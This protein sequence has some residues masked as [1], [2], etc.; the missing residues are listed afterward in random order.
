M[1]MHNNPY[2]P[3]PLNA[4]SDMA[5]PPATATKTAFT[6]DSVPMST[7]PTAPMLPPQPGRPNSTTVSPK[8]PLKGS[9][10]RKSGKSEG[11]THQLGPLFKSR[12]DSAPGLPIKAS[13]SPKYPMNLM[14]VPTSHVPQGADSVLLCGGMSLV[15][16]PDASA[17]EFR[18]V[19]E[20]ISST[21]KTKYDGNLKLV[22]YNIVGGTFV[23][24]EEEYCTATVRKALALPE[25]EDISIPAA[26][27]RTCAAEMWSQYLTSGSAAVEVSLV[28]NRICPLLDIPEIKKLVSFNG[29]I[30]FKRWLSFSCYCMNIDR[31]WDQEML[32]TWSEMKYVQL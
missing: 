14:R 12:R 8:S 1:S 32:T 7:T 26:L 11:I 31:S 18:L 28:V 21:N 30:Y 27:K 5:L 29:Y 6:S 23:R 20:T 13:Y 9:H 2:D 17:P 19:N 16:V 10:S 25:V 4:I 24:T 3:L 22:K 15:G